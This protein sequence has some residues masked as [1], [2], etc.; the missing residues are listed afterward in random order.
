MRLLLTATAMIG[1]F[2]LTTTAEARAPRRVRNVGV[3]KAKDAPKTTNT[4]TAPAA[5]STSSTANPQEMDRCRRIKDALN[6]NS[7]KLAD[8]I[9]DGARYDAEY[10]AAQQRIVELE[11]LRKDAAAEIKS[12][13]QRVKWEQKAFDKKCA[14][15]LNCEVYERYVGN[16]DG[17]MRPLEAALANIERQIADTN[18]EIAKL[19]GLVPP[20]QR[21][22]IK[23]ACANLKPG[24]TTQ[25]TI[26][27]CFTLMSDWN[28]IVTRINGLRNSLPGLESSYVSYSNRLSGMQGPIDEY[29]TY[30]NSFCKAS[31]SVAKVNDLRTRK[32][33]YNKL[34]NTIQKTVERLNKLKHVKIGK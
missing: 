11:Q 9:A 10:R 28:D 3:Q 32:D 7:R 19:E 22:Y 13:Q 18:A 26:D 29:S 31:A 15:V 25:D 2:T 5:T 24:E 14:N 27:K 16:L 1:L 33:R 12:L 4:E 20:V 23:L 21:D 8:T 30:L 34:G 17:R 6:G